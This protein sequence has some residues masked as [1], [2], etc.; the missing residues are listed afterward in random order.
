MSEQEEDKS[1]EEF[2]AKKSKSKK[3]KSKSKNFTT[4]KD[5]ADKKQLTQ[6]AVE[7]QSEVTPKVVSQVE[8][9]WKDFEAP[10]EMDYT[11][12]RVQ[13][14]QIDEEK[15]REEEK[16][17][18]NYECGEGEEQAR[19]ESSSG[20]WSKSS[21]QPSAAPESSEP[22][23]S[24][25]TGRYIPGAFKEKFRRE[26][27]GVAPDISSQAAFPSLSSA[28]TDKNRPDFEMVKRGN[29]TKDS[30]LEGH[31]TVNLE[32]RYDSLRR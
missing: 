30:S 21:A 2:F 4:S 5:I 23:V 16:D 10:A 18:D 14:L 26:R 24:R 3:S 29:K 22:V 13:A 1:L 25:P 31:G 11:G 32:N 7:E 27:V 12:L 15:E 17:E 20:P 8:E 19:G 28:A 6:S 9:Q